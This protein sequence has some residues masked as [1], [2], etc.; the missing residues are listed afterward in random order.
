MEYPGFK[1]NRPDTPATDRRPGR[2]RDPWPRKGSA[3]GPPAKAK[4]TPAAIQSSLTPSIEI[5][6]GCQRVPTASAHAG[7]TPALPVRGLGLGCWRFAA[8]GTGNRPWV[9]W[10]MVVAGP[11]QGQRPGRLKAKTQP[12]PRTEARSAGTRGVTRV[13]AWWAAHYDAER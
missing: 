1:I 5:V 6:A 3:G 2:R 4:Q 11:R 9:R 10:T 8:A 7:E 13:S 12:S